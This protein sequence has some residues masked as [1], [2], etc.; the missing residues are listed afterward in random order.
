MELSRRERRR[1][2]QKAAARR[3][4]AYALAGLSAGG[5]LLALYKGY[6]LACAF[7]A[8]VGF[9]GFLLS[10]LGGVRQYLPG[11]NHSRPYIRLLAALGYVLA[12]LA[13][14]GWAAALPSR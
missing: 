1:S 2:E 6:I 10:D 3:L 4:A 5:F 14:I 7:L 8:T 12:V 11:F 13:L 9:F